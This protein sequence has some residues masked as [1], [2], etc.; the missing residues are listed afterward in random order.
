MIEQTGSCSGIENYSRIIDRRE[1]GTPPSTLINYFP[2]DALIFVD[3]S[4]M[5]LPQL[6]AMY[7]GD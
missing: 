4:H 3:E 1:A 7:H 6:R 2:D 5:T